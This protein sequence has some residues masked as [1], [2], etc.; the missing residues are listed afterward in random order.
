MWQK[1]WFDGG[2]IRKTLVGILEED[3]TDEEIAHETNSVEDYDED[4]IE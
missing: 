3:V 2:V 1:L 4:E